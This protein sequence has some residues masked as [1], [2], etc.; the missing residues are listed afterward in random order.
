MA[1][2][3]EFP[4]K[5]RNFRTVN[6]TQKVYNLD[7]FT[8]YHCCDTFLGYNF[9]KVNHLRRGLDIPDF[10]VILFL[11]MGPSIQLWARQRKG[12][13]IQH[14]HQGLLEGC[15]VFL[16]EFHGSNLVYPK[17]PGCD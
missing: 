4:Q 17:T 13:P 7:F 8:K 9:Q 5:E 12:P 11:A 2:S 6:V 3:K 10:C 16:L 14:R 15:S 1:S